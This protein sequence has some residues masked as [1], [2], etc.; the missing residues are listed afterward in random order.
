MLL[1]KEVEIKW[2]PRNYKH[3]ISKGYIF[4]NWKD[5]FICKVEDLMDNSPVKI[6]VLCDYCLESNITTIV[7][8]K[9]QKYNAQREFIKKDACQH[10][11]ALK[12]RDICIVRHGVEHPNKL[13]ENIDKIKNTSLLKYGVDN[14]T[15]TEEYKKRVAE[16]NIKKYGFKAC[17]QN[18][19]IK[20]KMLNTNLE[21]YGSKYYSQTKEYI[22]KVNKTNLDKYGNIWCIASDVVRNKIAQTFYDNSS[23]KSSI[24]QRYLCDL[25]N[26]ILNYPIGR[27]NADIVFI[28]KKIIIEYDGGGHNLNVLMGRLT[29]IEHNTKEMKKE[30][31][32]RSKGWRIIRII[33]KYDN[34]PNDSKIIELYQ[35]AENYINTGHSW[36]NFDI[37]NNKIICS[38]YE[39]DYE[40]G[41][42]RKINKDD[43]NI[44][45]VACQS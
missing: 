10:C 13:K 29:Q 20:N 31:F 24:Q 16:T 17:I 28:N 32:V 4:T 12:Q 45:G 42:L 3:Y 44:R 14:Y 40:F 2:N 7:C 39:Q 1:T 8:K 18:E 41:E 9:Y 21:R 43:L 15:K 22:E 33:S 27:C 30:M 11:Q 6:E 36:I 38:Q 37:D 35:Y 34:L 5:S 19:D 23:Q 25:L 26:G